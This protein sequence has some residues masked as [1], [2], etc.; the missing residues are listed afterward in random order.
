M[1]CAANTDASGETGS[2]IQDFQ[3]LIRGSVG[4]TSR[5]FLGR[6]GC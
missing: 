5:L 4:D 1:N 3:Y 6:S 2:L